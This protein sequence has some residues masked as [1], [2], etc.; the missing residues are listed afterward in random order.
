MSLKWVLHKVPIDLL[1]S[2]PQVLWGLGRRRKSIGWLR[3][4]IRTLS[5]TCKNYIWLI[6]LRIQKHYLQKFIMEWHWSHSTDQPA[7]PLP[8]HPICPSNL[9]LLEVKKKKKKPTKFSV[10]LQTMGVGRKEEAHGDRV[11]MFAFTCI[12]SGAH[13]LVW[14]A[15]GTCRGSH[16]GS[17][18]SSGRDWLPTWGV[19]ELPVA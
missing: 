1:I 3:Y 12:A 11:G 18:W 15:P 7:S 4:A 10:N 6:K 9:N 16:K 14:L 17:L 19:S 8:C 5:S 2:L 13:Q